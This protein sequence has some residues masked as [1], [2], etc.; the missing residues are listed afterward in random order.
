[1]TSSWLK[2]G[3]WAPRGA[4]P[5]PP[6]AEAYE[7]RERWEVELYLRD[8][9]RLQVPCGTLREGVSREAALAVFAAVKDGAGVA[10]ADDTTLRGVEP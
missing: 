7:G 5:E 6:L 4:L 9:R 8:G 3:A 10:G 2:I 1:M